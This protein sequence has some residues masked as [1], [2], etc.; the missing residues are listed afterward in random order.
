MISQALI[1]FI[2]MVGFGFIGDYLIKSEFH[3]MFLIQSQHS[4]EQTKKTF[5]EE[6]NSFCRHLKQIE[7]PQIWLADSSGKVLC[8]NTGQTT[9]IDLAKDGAASLGSPLES[10]TWIDK[11]LAQAYVSKTLSRDGRILR[12]GTS[13]DLLNLQQIRLRKLLWSVIAAIFFIQITSSLIWTR[14]ITNPVS[15]ILRRAQALSAKSNKALYE[16]DYFGEEELGEWQEIESALENAR[17]DLVIKTESL[18]REQEELSTLMS[19]ISDAILATDSS[20]RFLFYNSRFA[21]QFM[22]RNFTQTQSLSVADVFRIPEILEAFQAVNKL[23]QTVLIQSIQLGPQEGP[24]NFYSISVS[25]LKKSD[26]QIY[27]AIGIFHDVTEL[28]SAEQIRIDFVAN[29]SHE[30]R[31]PLTSIKGFTDT[32][33]QDLRSNRTVDTSHMEVISRNVNRLMDLINDLLDL[34]ALESTDVIHKSSIAVEELTQ[35][36]ATQLQSRFETKRQKLQF[37]FATPKLLA[38]SRRVEQVLVNLLDNAHKYTPE[39]G[40]VK[41]V[42]EEDPNA[43]VLKVSDNGKG[44]PPEHQSRLFERFYRVDKARSREQ[45]GT[46]LG[47]A[48]V[49]HIMQRHQGSAEVESRPGQ[50]ATFICRFPKN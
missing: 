11:Q 40:A 5:P 32:V 12:V 46:G 44:I 19:A 16:Q 48:I 13:L 45:G 29:V 21:L 38:D 3:S 49:K 9:N 24:K 22:P 27:G 2:A 28:K 20:G 4:W 8:T 31:T 26:G 50:G 6:T 36:V 34:S 18:L 42:W 7:I 41:V 25:P 35:R 1:F 17:K 23:G 39:G 43:I 47:L 10:H 30:L 37:Q 33:I 15:R 14:R